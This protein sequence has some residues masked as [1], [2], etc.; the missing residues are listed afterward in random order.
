MHGGKLRSKDWIV[1]N[2]LLDAHMA[3]ADIYVHL[4]GLKNILILSLIWS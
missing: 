2:L 1:C 4:S 3:V